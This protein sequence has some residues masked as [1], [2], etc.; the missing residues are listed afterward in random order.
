MSGTL[1]RS[2]FVAPMDGRLIRDGAV[3]VRDGRVAAVGEY[4]KL[5]GAAVDVT[6][7]GQAVLIPGLVNAHTHLELSDC[8]PGERPMDGLEGWLVRM[9]TRTRLEPAE[10]E[11][12]SAHGVKTGLGQCLRFGVT[13]VGDISR[14]CHI[15]RPILREGP[16]RVTSFGEVM[17]MAQR[18]GL[19]EPRLELATD[20]SYQSEF[21]RIGITPH[22]PY[23]IEPEGYRRSL[24]AAKA[25]GMPL[26]THLAESRAEWEFLE[27]HRGPLKD[28]WDAWLT[29]DNQVPRY[30]GGPIRMAKELGL[31]DYP[32]V[33]A[34]V[35]YCSDEELELLAGG[36]ASVVY[37]PRTHDYFAHRP[38]RFREMMAHGINVAVGTDSCASSPDLNLVEDLRL[39]RRLYPELDAELLWRM[40]TVNGAKALRV[41]DEVG[42]IVAGKRADLVA[43][44]V[45]TDEPLLEVLEDAMQPCEVWIGGQSVKSA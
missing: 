17:A 41:E 37:C 26:A 15:T 7:A 14:Q 43:F 38:H 8:T 5:R 6:D 32:T 1:L 29:W 2:A 16:L 39:V 24:E 13:S 31:L 30:A 22:A 35:N 20:R 40:A 25:N 19:L 42:T 12:R 27:E 45:S 9:L 11:S 18:R 21:V 44:A 10:L 34:H 33:L 28:L 3:W 36:R 23:S 4:R